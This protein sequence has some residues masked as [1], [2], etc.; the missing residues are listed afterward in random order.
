[1][2]PGWSEADKPRGHT[3]SL[4]V[5]AIRLDTRQSST[6]VLLLL[7]LRWDFPALLWSPKM[8][9]NLLQTQTLRGEGGEDSMHG[10]PLAR[11]SWC[12]CI[13]NSI[14]TDKAKWNTEVLTYATQHGCKGR[15]SLRDTQ[16]DYTTRSVHWDDTWCGSL[17]P[18]PAINPLPSSAV[19]Y[20][21]PCH[22]SMN[23]L[24]PKDT[25][26]CEWVTAQPSDIVLLGIKDKI[27]CPSWGRRWPQVLIHS[28]Q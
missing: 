4:P 19:L 7:V 9:S 13:I 2:E 16:R 18:T 17:S 12:P 27:S 25:D 6:L 3:A 22:P 1:M 26:S 5:G 24:K 11:K 23:F 14:L 15:V 21:P 10:V 20:F 28:R 8:H